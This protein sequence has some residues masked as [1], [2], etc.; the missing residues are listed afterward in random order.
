M[1][2]PSNPFYSLYT[3]TDSFFFR[4]K[5]TKPPNRNSHVFHRSWS[6]TSI[7]HT[8]IICWILGSHFFAHCHVTIFSPCFCETPYDSRYDRFEVFFFFGLTFSFSLFFFALV[9]SFGGFYMSTA[10]WSEF[11]RTVPPWTMVLQSMCTEDLQ[12]LH[13][14]NH[15]RRFSILLFFS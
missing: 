15:L 14:I 6:C 8:L 11:L 5:T 2:K 10:I 7:S 1:K 4:P 12:A 13:P 9:A 3:M